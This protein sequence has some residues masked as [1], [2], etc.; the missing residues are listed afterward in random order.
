MMQINL[1]DN[2]NPQENSHFNIFQAYKG[3]KYI[4]PPL[5]KFDGISLFT[6][7][8][9]IHPVVDA[10]E[11][12]YKFGTFIEPKSIK[13][14]AYEVLKQNPSLID[15]FD[16]IFT[17]DEELLE[18]SD[19]VKLLPLLCGSYFLPGDHK[20]YKKTKNLSIVANSK[21]FAE[22]HRFRHQVIDH[23][24]SRMDCY[25][26]WYTDL[27]KD[28][29]DEPTDTLRGKWLKGT[30]NILRAFKDYRY[31]MVIHSI[32]NKNYF[33]EKLLNCFFTGTVPIVWSPTNVGDFFDTNGCF[34]F[35]NL[36]ELGYILDKLGE[37]DYNSRRQAIKNNFEIAHKYISFDKCLSELITSHIKENN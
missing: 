26:P 31:A 22:G 5:Q 23:Y 36:E 32:R 13:P 33:D 3:V 6:D 30:G 18:I 16:A 15:K 21:S 10:V 9:L 17:H 8:L 11:S 28:Y 24:G 1:F 7:E 2:N 34:Q 19:R 4:R 29:V 12:K 35:S 27:Y 20:I 14:T 25:G 37:D